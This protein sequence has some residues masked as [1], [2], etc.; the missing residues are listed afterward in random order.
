[1]SAIGGFYACNIEWC[2]YTFIEL[3]HVHLCAIVR[4]VQPAP[5][6]NPRN[7]N[8]VY[9]SYKECIC[10]HAII[11]VIE[12]APVDW[13]NGCMHMYYAWSTPCRSQYIPRCTL[14]A[15]HLCAAF[16]ALSSESY[17]G[18][19]TRSW[20][21]RDEVISAIQ[22]PISCCLVTAADCASLPGIL[23]PCIPK[24]WLQ[25]GCCSTGR[26]VHARRN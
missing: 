20:R 16:G 24:M 18:C 23:G 4:S 17:R 22:G 9:S 12:Q 11:S 8:C 10:V 5:W 7:A 26:H 6:N 1:M 15:I 2:I 21:K 25:D 3:Q 13:S 14:L 19:G